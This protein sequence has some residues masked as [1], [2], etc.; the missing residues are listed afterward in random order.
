MD[1]QGE[2]ASS[3]C[4]NSVIQA[5][6][7][8]NDVAK[9]EKWLSAALEK[10]IEVSGN[11]F[12]NFVNACVRAADLKKAEGWLS[13]MSRRGVSAVSSYNAVASAWARQGDLTRADALR[14]RQDATSRQR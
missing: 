11:T 3:F 13:E 9:A 8:I 2:Q 4:Y 1:K 12:S 10:E 6:A 14:R 5:W 7:N